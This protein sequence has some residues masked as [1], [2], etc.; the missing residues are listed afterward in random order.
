MQLDILEYT[1]LLEPN[2]HYALQRAEH[3][4]RQKG[5]VGIRGVPDFE[6]K[7][8]AYVVAARA[9]SALPDNIKQKY[10]PNRDSG[11][12]EGYELG[13]EKF[14]N[15]EG[16]WQIDD[17]KA[18]YYASIPDDSCNIWPQEVD[19]KSAYLDLGNL[20]FKVGKLLLNAVGLDANAGLNHDLLK[21]QGRM[22]HYHKE[23]EMTDSNPDWCGAHLDHGVFTGLMPAYYFRDQD[24]VDEPKEAGLYITP[25]DGTDFEKINADDKSIMLFQVGEFGQ[26][27]SND[28]IKATKHIVKKAMGGVER[29]SFALFYSPDNDM[30][31]QSK[32]ILTQDAR[33]TNNQDAEGR[34]CFSQWHLASFARYRAK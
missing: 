7:S 23:G 33:Y 16:K 13:A 9:F 14:K 10:I 29:F 26:L 25:S 18:S 28:R 1:D 15:T 31:I 2:N 20:I 27:I 21:G 5:I 22:L 8:R 24:E 19:L 12:T 6:K 11:Q 34:I 4:L 3:A 32:S 30:V 17:K